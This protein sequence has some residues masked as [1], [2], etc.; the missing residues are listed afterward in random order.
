[1]ESNSHTG[2]L[3]IDFK[4]RH[5]NP[6]TANQNVPLELAKY[7]G[8][9]FKI[10]EPHMHIYVEGYKTLAWAIPLS[11]TNFNTKEFKEQGDLSKIIY[12]FAKEINLTSK[13]EIQVGLL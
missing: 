4:G 5:S 11:D 13:F 1:M 9:Q 10:D 3:R 8:K 6:V 2:L 12:N 7:A